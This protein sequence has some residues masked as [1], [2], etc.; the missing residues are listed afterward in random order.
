MK[1]V[2]NANYNLRTV[3]FIILI[4]IK[5]KMSVRLDTLKLKNEKNRGRPG[6]GF[7]LE[8]LRCFFTLQS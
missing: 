3:Q 4:S 6:G 5:K 8:R 2:G 1:F 7:N